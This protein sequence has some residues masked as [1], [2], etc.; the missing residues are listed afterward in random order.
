MRSKMLC[1]QKKVQVNIKKMTAM[2]E[3]DKYSKYS[4]YF[5]KRN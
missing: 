1:R 5:E 4:L 2:E 3:Q